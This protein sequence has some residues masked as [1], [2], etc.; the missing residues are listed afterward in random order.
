MYVLASTT[1]SI[2]GATLPTNIKINN[3]L[4]LDESSLKYIDLNNVFNK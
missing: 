1:G 4:K 3:L 2:D